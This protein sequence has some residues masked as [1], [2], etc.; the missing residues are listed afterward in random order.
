M[1][2]ELFM[3]VGDNATSSRSGNMYVRDL[4]RAA[5]GMQDVSSE[6]FLVQLSTYSAEGNSQ[7]KISPLVE[8]V[9]AAVGL[10]R[11]ATIRADGHMMTMI[12]GRGARV[13]EGER[14]RSFTQWLGR[15]RSAPSGR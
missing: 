2:F 11:F 1:S 15:V 13:D 9:I 4:I 3:I 5:A 8:W 10:D 12:F 7:K 6:A 14:G